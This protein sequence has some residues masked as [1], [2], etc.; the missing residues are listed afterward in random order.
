MA[1]MAVGHPAPHWSTVPLFLFILATAAA[2]TVIV[3]RVCPTAS[4]AVLLRAGSRGTVTAW[5]REPR[6]RLWSLPASE[7]PPPAASQCHTAAPCAPGAPCVLPHASPDAVPRWHSAAALPVGAGSLSTP[8]PRLQAVHTLDVFGSTV[9][10]TAPRVVLRAGHRF[11]HTPLWN[12]SWAVLE[13]DTQQCAGRT[14]AESAGGATDVVR[15]F[16]LSL[17]ILL[18]FVGTLAAGLL[19]R[20]CRPSSIERD[21]RSR[22]AAAAAVAAAEGWGAGAVC[23]HVQP[24]TVLADG[25][26]ACGL[27][28][29]DTAHC[30]GT[31]CPGAELFRGTLEDGRSVTVKRVSKALRGA[32]A[33]HEAAFFVA[34]ECVCKGAVSCYALEEDAAWFYFAFTPCRETLAAWVL[35][36]RDAA[37]VASPECAHLMLGLARGVQWLHQHGFVHG[38]LSP[39]KVVVDTCGNPRICDFGLV[40]QEQ[41]QPQSSA[42]THAQAHTHAPRT[43]GWQAPEVLAHG[44]G[45]VSCAADVFALGCMFQCMATGRHP[46]GDTAAER[47]ARVAA[48]AP[49][50]AR[51]GRAPLLLHLVQMAVRR[52][53]A[54][55]ALADDVVGHMFF[56]PLKKRIDFVCAVSERLDSA[57]GDA[58][59]KAQMEEYLGRLPELHRW[60]SRVAPCLFGDSTNRRVV[61]YTTHSDVLRLIRNK[62]RHFHDLDG[63]EKA[64]LVSFPDGFFR[65]FDDRFPALFVC[66]Y[67]FVCHTLSNEPGFNNIYF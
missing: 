19:L 3:E 14:N 16:A 48:Y 1:S 46:F 33:E 21:L 42:P 61:A 13:L 49:D 25:V 55:R 24:S 35:R 27:V 6:T 44:D 23:R 56:W 22:A 47:D 15:A 10:G 7:L 59:V 40:V 58:L 34:T 45:A 52:E 9:L 43:P 62:A 39:E 67:E 54:Q 66:V 38:D 17:G 18:G 50:F 64:L 65:Y 53:A 4:G 41:A 36:H 12:C 63:C 51:L 57:P 31:V 32:A 37:E 20:L 26:V 29:C 5:R 60:Q 30:L 11:A 2:E 8:A 28:R